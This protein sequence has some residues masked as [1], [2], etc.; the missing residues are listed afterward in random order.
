MCIALP[1]MGQGKKDKKKG[2]PKTEQA[3]PGTT[4]AKSGANVKI[5]NFDV[6]RLLEIFSFIYC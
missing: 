6:S 1:A 5:H 4:D 3:A 2:T